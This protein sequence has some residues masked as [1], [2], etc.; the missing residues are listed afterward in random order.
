LFERT[1]SLDLERYKGAFRENEIEIG[2]LPELT[3]SDLEKLG[4]PLEPRKRLLK[5][6][7]G[8][9]PPSADTEGGTV[10]RIRLCL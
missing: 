7:R 8:L 5:A 9:E 3:D 10:M 6:I 2:D 4:I 1:V